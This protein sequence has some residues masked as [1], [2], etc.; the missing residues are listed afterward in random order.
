MNEREN[1][2]GQPLPD[3]QSRQPEPRPYQKKPWA[4]GE[5]TST[6][7]WQT[8][9]WRTR[10]AEVIARTKVCEWCKIEFGPGV[11]AV[12]SHRQD[13]YKNPDGTTDWAAYLAMKDDEVDVICKPCH[14]TWTRKGLK[15]TDADT[16]CPACGRAKRRTYSVC[17]TCRF[18]KGIRTR[19]EEIQDFVDGLAHEDF[20]CNHGCKEVYVGS[21]AAG[22]QTFV[23]E[24]RAKEIKEQ[25]PEF[26]FGPFKSA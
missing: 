15:P 2:D 20:T 10:R 14:L 22:F 16:T 9:Q 11:H 21:E 24:C 8:K 13:A 3:Q 7:P 5:K 6:K 12:I 1:Q 25:Y 19:D 23:P 17:W 18:K 26:E 4:K